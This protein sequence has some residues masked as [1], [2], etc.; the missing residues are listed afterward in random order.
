MSI[1]RIGIDLLQIVILCAWIL[2]CAVNLGNKIPF[3]YHNGIRFFAVTSGSMS[4]TIPTG[5]IVYLD[6]HMYGDLKEGDII[7]FNRDSQIVTHR[8]FKK[9]IK[10]IGN[11]NQGSVTEISFSTKG[12]A[13]TSPDNGI[14]TAKD[15]LGTYKF[16]IPYIGYVSTLTKEPLGFFL[17][18][19]LPGVAIIVSEIMIII[20]DIKSG[21]EKKLKVEV[22]RIANEYKD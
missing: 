7:T 19:I 2:F 21:Y 14:V 20:S 18:V 10:E 9:N 15:I 13:N 5:S 22:D 11:D 16:H 6:K 1:K 17:I 3:L 12:D 4:P 8:I